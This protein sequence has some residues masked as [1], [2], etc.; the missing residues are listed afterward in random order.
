M[1]PQP[2]GEFGIHYSTHVPFVEAL[3]LR[4][5]ISTFLSDSSYLYSPCLKELIDED[6]VLATGYIWEFGNSTVLE[7]L[8]VSLDLPSFVGD[9]GGLKTQFF[10]SENEED[11]NLAKFEW[12]KYF[13]LFFNLEKEANEIYEKVVSEYQ[14][15]E[16]NAEMLASDTEEQ[17]TVLWASW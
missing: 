2:L 7:N 17:P 11:S 15:A 13:S 5:K 14:C 10:V 16:K 12:V 8:G 4:T 1:H 3:D 9:E 6:K